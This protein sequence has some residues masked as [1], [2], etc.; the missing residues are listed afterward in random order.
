M[1]PPKDHQK[2]IDD[3]AKTQIFHIMHVDS[4]FWL[5]HIFSFRK[6]T[7]DELKVVVKKCQLPTLLVFRHS[8]GEIQNHFIG[9]FSSVECDDTSH[10]VD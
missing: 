7:F 8:H 6:L 10:I 4:S 1:V 9:V 2:R 3:S 5:Q